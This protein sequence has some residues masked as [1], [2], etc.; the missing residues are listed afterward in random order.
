MANRI[1][2]ITLAPK[3]INQSADDTELDSLEFIVLSGIIHQGNS[4][5]FVELIRQ[6]ILFLVVRC[7]IGPSVASV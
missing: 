7:F 4:E 5:V 1:I 6:V 3:I 2:I